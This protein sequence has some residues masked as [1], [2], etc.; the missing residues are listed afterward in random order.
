MR[1]MK[2]HSPCPKGHRSHKDN[3]SQQRALTAARKARS[4][5]ERV[6]TM[7]ENECYCVDV[8]QQALAVQGLWKGMIR[9]VFESHLRTC[10]RDAMHS[11]NAQ[12]QDRV[13]EEVI[14]V[15]RLSDRS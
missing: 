9:H 15:M 2:P 13:L 10:F 4:H 12:K 8:L 5:I 7:L 3:I 1:V 11:G 6:I 14:R